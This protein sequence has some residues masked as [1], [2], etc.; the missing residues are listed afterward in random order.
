MRVRAWPVCLFV[1]L[2][3]AHKACAQVAPDPP[4][5]WVAVL[6]SQ[7]SQPYQQAI[8]A[9]EQGLKAETLK[10]QP[11]QLLQLNGP[12]SPTT[13][14]GRIG[15]YV[16]LGSQACERLANEPRQ[17]T[18]LCAMVAMAQFEKIRDRLSPAMALQTAALFLDQPLNRQMR[19][20]RL[21]W[22]KVK[23]LGVLLGSQSATQQ[24]AMRN[25]AR[26]A[27]FDLVLAKRDKDAPDFRALFD[28]F[29]RS[30]VLWAL[31][32]PDVYSVQTSYNILLAAWRSGVPVMAFSPA[33]V[34]AGA[35]LGLFATPAQVGQ[36]AAALTLSLL[37]S[38]LPP[39]H[40]DHARLF[41]V[42]VNTTV[43]AS[44]GMTLDAQVLQRQLRALEASP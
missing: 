39:G 12:Y 37:R 5:F 27:G 41:E 21:A 22:P 4:P 25:T 20:M 14:D 1:F 38:Q 42:S 29:K 34:N 28:L 18:V 43:A 10:G 3:V 33:Y 15:F 7:P 44:F 32:D 24:L 11:L 40:T 23:H 36:D 35:V 19:L 2:W 26:A 8:L 30:E 16:A 13:A 31:P 17:V 9:L 6:S